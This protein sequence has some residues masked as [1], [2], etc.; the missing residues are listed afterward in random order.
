MI[1]RHFYDEKTSTLTY[2]VHDEHARVG[3]VIDTVT[4]FDPKSRQSYAA[5]A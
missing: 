2:V 3:V 1:I 5:P 4:D